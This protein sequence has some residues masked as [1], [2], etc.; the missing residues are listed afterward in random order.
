MRI[1]RP[2]TPREL[3]LYRDHLMRLSPGDR[4][5][6]FCQA[7]GE[8]AID[9]HIARL[10]PFD[11][12]LIG[13][14]EDGVLRGAAEL[15]WLRP[16]AARRAELAL[17]VEAAYRHRGL[18]T[19]LSARA[20]AAARNRGIRQVDLLCLATNRAMIAIAR[21][22]GAAIAVEAGQAELAI[23]L[24]AATALDRWRETIDHAIAAWAGAAER[25]MA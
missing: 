22:F 2:L 10:T 8:A 11:G 16:A 17:S 21:K 3:P 20:L 4:Y 1:V 19:L 23:P 18:G 14:F 7:V 12:L 25:L 9:R 15:A 5:D 6:R 24:E 13:A